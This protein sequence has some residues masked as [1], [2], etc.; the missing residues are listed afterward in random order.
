MKKFVEDSRGIV[1]RGFRPPPGVLPLISADLL[2]EYLLLFKE[3]DLAAN[4][5][6]EQVNS[7]LS[8][9]LE[10]NTSKQKM[11]ITD[12]QLHTNV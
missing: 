9:I 8:K 4:L 6:A 12:L 10:R 2:S 5:S 11:L 7:T 3:V 1:K